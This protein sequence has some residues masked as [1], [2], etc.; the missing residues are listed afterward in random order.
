MAG[1]LIAIVGSADPSRTY[2]PP[3]TTGVVEDMARGLGAELARQGC[4][5]LVFDPGKSYIEGT[6]VTGFVTRGSKTGAE[7][8]KGLEI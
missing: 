7:I 2:D 5:I 6:V 3:V 4:R 1:P 8:T